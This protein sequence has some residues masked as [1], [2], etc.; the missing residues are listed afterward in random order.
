M[1]RA[2]RFHRHFAALAVAAVWL[3]VA[4]PTLGR[5]AGA[6]G[7]AH[8][9]NDGWVAV[10]T[11]TGLRYLPVSAFSDG[12]LP[13]TP[14]PGPDEDCSYCPLLSVMVPAAIPALPTTKTKPIGPPHHSP[15]DATI[16]TPHPCGL[17]SRGPPPVLLNA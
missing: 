4:M 15:A 8:R 12:D 3:L 7:G 10:C 1:I 9:A 11:A 14:V 16:E 13:P 2:R 6:A 17:G 5:W